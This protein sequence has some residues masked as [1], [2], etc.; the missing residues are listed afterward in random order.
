MT[1]S[2]FG[3]LNSFGIVE[4]ELPALVIV[5]IFKFCDLKSRLTLLSLSKSWNQ[6]IIPKFQKMILNEHLEFMAQFVSTYN[7]SDSDPERQVKRGLLI[8]AFKS[9][10]QAI[11]TKFDKQSSIESMKSLDFQL[12]C[13][14][15]ASITPEHLP[16]RVCFSDEYYKTVTGMHSIQTR[17]NRPMLNQLI[18]SLMYFNALST[19]KPYNTS[20][21]S[22]SA[23]VFLPDGDV[24]LERGGTPD[25][26]R[27]MEHFGFDVRQFLSLSEPFYKIRSVKDELIFASKVTV[28]FVAFMLWIYYVGVEESDVPNFAFGSFIASISIIACFLYKLDETKKLQF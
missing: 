1:I 5:K 15:A 12:A 3:A 4:K 20:G 6:I 19:K 23:T 7:E 14:I 10:A 9:S 24:I 2:G 16:I 18:T 28:A 26:K 17:Y 21:W 8:E 27:M 13:K 25:I 22:D 11:Y